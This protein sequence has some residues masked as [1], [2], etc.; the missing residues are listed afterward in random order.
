MFNDFNVVISIT[1]ASKPYNEAIKL[2]EDVIDGI[3]R[4]C[5]P[6]FNPRVYFHPKTF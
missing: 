2:S 3:C 4:N 1:L 5:N 6:K